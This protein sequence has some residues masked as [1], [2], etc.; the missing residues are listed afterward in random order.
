M[1]LSIFLICHIKLHEQVLPTINTQDH[2]LQVLWTRLKLGHY[3]N[4]MLSGQASH[5]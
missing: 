3:V 2:T 5:L 4:K 1:L